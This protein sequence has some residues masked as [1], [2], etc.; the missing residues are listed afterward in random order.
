MILTGTHKTKDGKP[1]LLRGVWIRQSDGV[2]ETATRS[3][4]GGISWQP[5]F[6]IVFR[7]HQK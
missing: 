6:D 3:I 1:S 7:P 2:R 5:E 4:D